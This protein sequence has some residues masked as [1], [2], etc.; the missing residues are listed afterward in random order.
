VVNVP[1]ASKL[2]SGLQKLLP[3]K[4]LFPKQ[5][6]PQKKSMKNFI[7][8]GDDIIDF[9]LIKIRNKNIFIHCC[10]DVSEVTSSYKNTR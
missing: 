8:D 6:I 5:N 4:S 1:S 3:L 7:S 9:N 2:C 10:L